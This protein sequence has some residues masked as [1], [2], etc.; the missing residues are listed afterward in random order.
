MMIEEVG[1][2]YH[3]FNPMSQYADKPKLIAAPQLWIESY[4]DFFHYIDPKTK[5][6]DFFGEPQ[7]RAEMA[8]LEMLKKLYPW[9]Q[10]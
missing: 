2:S 8:Y 7:E 5:N 9:F 6:Q 1:E 10:L 4:L 3:I